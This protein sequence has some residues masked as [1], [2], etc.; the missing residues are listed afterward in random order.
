MP[1]LFDTT[2]T[3]RPR[4]TIDRTI[5]V[6][7]GTFLG[8]VANGMPRAQIVQNWRD[9]RYPDLNPTLARHSLQERG[10]GMQTTEKS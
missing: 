9:G 7:N 1:D 5:G 6:G 2:P 8:H 4:G 3:Q 10:D